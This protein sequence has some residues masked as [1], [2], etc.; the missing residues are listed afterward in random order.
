MKITLPD[1]QT[2]ELLANDEITERI[3]RPIDRAKTKMIHV[4]VGM[5]QS[6]YDPPQLWPDTLTCVTYVEEKAVWPDGVSA[7]E[8]KRRE[9]E[10]ESR[11][12]KNLGIET[13]LSDDELDLADDYQT[14]LILGIT[15]AWSYSVP[16]T[17]DSVL[18]LK[19]PVL[20]FLAKKCQEVFDNTEVD[21]SPN[22]NPKALAQDSSV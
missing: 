3:F 6:G 5:N 7:E 20:E 1:G 22:P 15:S 16:I 8:A 14:K 10:I 19:K 11:T 21:L 9:A 17:E 18:G 2:A 12:L 13:G 4:S